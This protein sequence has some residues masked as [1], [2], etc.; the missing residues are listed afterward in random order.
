M[1]FRSTTS[2]S[3]A[4]YAGKQMTIIVVKGTTITA[5]S[6]M[7]I[8]QMAADVNG[9]YS[10]SSYFTKEVLSTITPFNVY[11][12]GETIATPFFHTVQTEAQTLSGKVIGV[13]SNNNA[14]TVQLL[15]A[16][17][18]AVVETT[19]SDA[20]SGIYQFSAIASAN[21]KIKVIKSG[22]L[23]EIISETFS[24]VSKSAADISLIAGDTDG[25]NKIDVVDYAKL[26]LNY[27]STSAVSSDFNS[28]GIVNM[29]D[30]TMIISNFG[31]LG[32]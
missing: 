11:I 6:I 18:N 26:I 17:T 28:D 5:S 23:A 7:Y 20:V 12:G 2:G 29:T 32:K 13:G 4:S 9:A 8:D 31:K 30:L 16:T 14:A 24:G 21:Y 25:N 10:F 19:T 3:D 27:K 22:Y 15:N 1:L